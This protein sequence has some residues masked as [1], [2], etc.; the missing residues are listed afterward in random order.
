[1][2][3]LFALFAVL[4]ACAVVANA[5]QTAYSGMRAVTSQRGAGALNGLIEISGIQGS[6]QPLV[7][8]LIVADPTARGGQREYEVSG[9]NILS[10]RTPVRPT[11]SSNAVPIQV[12]SLN[13]DS[14]G[15]FFAANEQAKAMKVGFDSAN[16]RLASRDALGTPAWTV[17]LVGADGVTRAVVEVSA[18]DG[19][20]LAASLGSHPESAEGNEEAIGGAIGK[21]RDTLLQAGQATKRTFLKGVGTVQKW[22]TGRRTIGE[23]DE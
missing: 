22:L 3:V 9:G 2:K 8:R 14:D 23:S 12:A 10:E 4:L 16:Y 17:D 7:W 1:M 15:A 18:T 13:L 20:V 21:T 19:V 11:V 5:Q 6:P